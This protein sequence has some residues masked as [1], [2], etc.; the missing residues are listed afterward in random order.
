MLQIFLQETL[1]QIVHD[2][3]LEG[4]KRL[5]FLR[6]P[7]FEMSLFSG[8]KHAPV[9]STEKNNSAKVGLALF[10]GRKRE[11]KCLYHA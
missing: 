1:W 8:G 6:S 10:L 4:G 7:F 5:V 2:L 3:D 9:P 11:E